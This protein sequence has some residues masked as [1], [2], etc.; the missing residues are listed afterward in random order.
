MNDAVMVGVIL[1]LVFGAIIFYL[2]NR[3]SMTERKMGLFEGVLTDLKMMLDSAPF[4]SGPPPAMYEFEPTPEYL[5]AISGPVP[6]QKDDV[7]EVSADEDYQQTLEQALEGAAATEALEGSGANSS[8]AM[9]MLHIDDNQPNAL[10][11]S[12]SVTKLSPDLDSLTVKELNG[13]AKQKGLSVPAGTRRK[14]LIEL[15]K[16]GSVQGTMLDGPGPDDNQGAPL[17]SNAVEVT[18]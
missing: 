14:E 17:E 15:L 10:Q 16:K 8:D 2:Y 7:E 18:L 12:I 3:L 9:R 1:T 13:L 5:N 6:L 11:P 4:A